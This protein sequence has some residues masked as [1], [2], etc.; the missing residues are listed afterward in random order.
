[1]CVFRSLKVKSLKIV[2]CDKKEV[3]K[4]FLC[5][6]WIEVASIESWYLEKL[7][8]HCIGRIHSLQ[9]FSNTDKLV[10]FVSNFRSV[11]HV[12]CY[13]IYTTNRITIWCFSH[14]SIFIF[15]C[16]IFSQFI[17]LAVFFLGDINTQFSTNETF[18][19]KI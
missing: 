6:E 2:L 15:Y 12:H 3:M 13:H 11:V 16:R 9:V 17:L 8:H 4:K 18:N 10:L 1:M 5:I 19:I 7:F 14:F